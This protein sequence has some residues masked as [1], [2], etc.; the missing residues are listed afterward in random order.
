MSTVLE[1][2]QALINRAS[3]TPDDGGCQALIAER[4]SALGFSHHALA[5]GEVSNQLSL[6]PGDGPL[7]LFLGHTDVVPP[8]PEAAWQSPPFHATERGGYLYGRG[9]ADMKSSLAA[10]VCA[11][12]QLDAIEH[13]G[14]RVGLLLTSDE[15][16]PAKDGIRAVTHAL[17]EL[18][19]PIDWCLVGEPSSHA[20][21]GDVIRIGRRGSLSAAVRF[22]GQ[23][24][25]V[26]YPAGADNPVP[27]LAAFLAALSATHWDEGNAAFPPTSLQI[28]ELATDTH[29]SNVVPGEASAQFNLRFAPTSSAHS[30]R[31]R[32]E[33]LIEEHAGDQRSAI[34]WHLSAEPFMSEPGALRAAIDEVIETHTGTRP[35]ANTAGGTS[36]GRFIAPLGAEVIEFGPVNASIH[37][38][39]ERIKVDELDALSRCYKDIILTLARI[40]QA[41]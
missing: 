32:V 37:Q 38:V 30:L 28:T 8:G 6:S 19:G 9:A 35:M 22:Y 33:Q 14:I 15:E 25:H 29:A 40:T 26:A 18:A 24:G 11:C 23:Q 17:S 27:R 3:V 13:L 10:F 20:Q 4:L 1:L 34:D 31:E 41:R 39:D 16:G 36:D 12:E 5:R 7:L 21:L 2:T